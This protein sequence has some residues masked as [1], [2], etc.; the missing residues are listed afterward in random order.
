MR[1]KCITGLKLEQ[2]QKKNSIML[3]YNCSNHV[4]SWSGRGGRRRHGTVEPVFPKTFCCTYA[5]YYFLSFSGRIFLIFWQNF[6]LSSRTS[7]KWLERDGNSVW[8][9]R[10]SPLS[11]GSSEAAVRVMKLDRGLMMMT[12][13]AWSLLSTESD[14]ACVFA[15]DDWLTYKAISCV[16]NGAYLQMPF[17]VVDFDIQVGNLH[18]QS[19]MRR[20]AWFY[21]TRNSAVA[22]KPRRTAWLT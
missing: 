4:M 21:W 3:C 18:T 10:Q 12:C 1:K 9:S 16:F 13:I 17:D 2:V 6:V 5:P 11:D 14:I 7:P 20:F 19:N 8:S 22:N 15:S